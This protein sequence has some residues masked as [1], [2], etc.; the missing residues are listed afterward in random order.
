MDG[1]YRVIFGVIKHSKTA[2][3]MVRTAANELHTTEM[4][5]LPHHNKVTFQTHEMSL[6]LHYDGYSLK[7]ENPKCCQECGRTGSLVLVT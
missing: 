3:V 6:C 7:M 5:M 2:M 4:N 1:T